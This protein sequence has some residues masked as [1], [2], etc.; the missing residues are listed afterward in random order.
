MEMEMMYSVYTAT[1]A[2]LLMTAPM[3]TIRAVFN[4]HKD[5]VNRIEREVAKINFSQV[6]F[7]GRPNALNLNSVVIQRS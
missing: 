7:N 5:A 4:L 3:E 2:R 1:D 6:Y